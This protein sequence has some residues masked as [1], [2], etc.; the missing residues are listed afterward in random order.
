MTLLSRNFK[1][2]KVRLLSLSKTKLNFW[3]T[4][5]TA[6]KIGLVG[7]QNRNNYI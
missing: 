1:P 7:R 6:N 5:K 2:L 3:S 4:G